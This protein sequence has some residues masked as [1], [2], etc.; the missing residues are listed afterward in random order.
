MTT[1][2]IPF[3]PRAKKVLDLSLREALSLGHNHIGTEHILLGLVRENEGVATQILLDCGVDAETIRG[4]M[5]RRLSGPHGAQHTGSVPTPAEPA[6]LR[7]VR[8][9]GWPARWR[10]LVVEVAVGEITDEL[11]DSYGADGWA[12]AA[13]VPRGEQAGLVFTQPA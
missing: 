8:P 6:R 2:Q 7:R 11:L 12:L 3:T 13:T 4:E 5:K 10:Y 1:G 9:G